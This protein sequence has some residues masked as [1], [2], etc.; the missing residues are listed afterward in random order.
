[1]LSLSHLSSFETRRA[2]QLG[3]IAVIFLVL[4]YEITSLYQIRASTNH[5]TEIVEINNAMVTHLNKMRDGIRQR[6]ILMNQ[7]LS[8]R[9]PFLREEQSLKF[10]AI[11][12]PVRES[13][14]KLQLLPITHEEDLILK[15]LVAMIKLAQPVNQ[16]AVREMM[17]SVG[18]DK[19]R[20]L[21]KKAQLMQGQLMESMEQLIEIRKQYEMDFVEKSK[22][23]Y[24]AVFFWSVLS[25]GFIITIA[26]LIARITTGFVSRK[27]IELINK[28]AELEKV[29]KVALE[30]THTK[31]AFLATMSHEIR[32]PL[33]AI[34]GFAEINLEHAVS[35]ENRKKH[36]QSIVRNGRHLL[37][38]INDILDI[39][40]VEANR[41]EFEHKKMSLFAVFQD[42]EH[43]I[44]PQVKEKGLN[45]FIEYEYPLPEFILG[46]S[47]RLKQVIL[48]ICTNAIKF[49][50]S[51][52]INIKVSCNMEEQKL[53]VEIIDTGI[54]MTDQ[55]VETIFDVFTQAD[56]SITRKYGGTGLGL[57]LSK[58]FAEGMGGGI[59]AS[60]LLDIGSRFIVSI[61]TG[62][63]TGFK[64]IENKA[65]IKAKNKS[66]AS[67]DI[68]IRNVKGRVLLV[69]DNPDN[70]QL[71][72]VLLAKTG[73]DVTI[74][75]NGKIAV[76]T[77]LNEPFDLI[78]MD[79]QMPVMG[80]IEATRILREKGYR[81]PIVSLTA[82]AMKQDR[83]ESI[84]AGSN[85]YITKP[86]NK[87][88]FYYT[89]YKYLDKGND[90]AAISRDD[91]EGI[92]DDD[93]GIIS[94]KNKFILGLPEKYNLIKDGFNNNQYEIVKKEVHKLKG[95]GGSFG[96]QELTDISLEIELALS[97]ND[98]KL[99]HA[100]I[101]EMGEF[102]KKILKSHHSSQVS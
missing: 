17:L 21:V 24:E 38:I 29:T 98:T 77:A 69:E 67:E 5:L 14:E 82:N 85:D 26:T 30:A 52:R 37:Q 73:A 44:L 68:K 88:N 25:V 47:L 94:L 40:K 78:F 83:D 48:N 20:E 91:K 81:G 74:A 60:S 36:T 23:G 42:I 50:E 99:C 35:D 87:L 66:A 18:S 7:M 92:I 97:N 32:T 34:I 56:S 64:H 79:M 51:G 90:Q 63:I 4:V 28:N 96:C 59:I 6:Q 86:V 3:F 19:S 58:Q 39:S 101:F 8:T 16:Q 89:V 95:L 15:D 55:Q 65:Q 57:A 13:R 80:G 54:G 41:I 100:L 76:E 72:S 45:L 53:Y 49:T 33:T 10:F 31:S 27:N 2:V 9:D 1:M 75:A 102:I 12:R 84:K 61:D 93:P 46:D 71:F 11:A 22:R 70:Q 43:I 62:D